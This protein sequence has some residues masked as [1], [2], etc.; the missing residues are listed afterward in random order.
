MS[1][2]GVALRRRVV[3]VRVAA[4][5]AWAG[6]VDEVVNLRCWLARGRAGSRY[7]VPRVGDRVR[8]DGK[9]AWLVWGVSIRAGE[10][11][12]G[13]GV[14]GLE[15]LDPIGPD[16]L[17]ALYAASTSTELVEP[18]DSNTVEET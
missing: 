18:I 9:G 14:H 4:W 5:R 12:L 8:V 17:A 3:A 11:T 2:Q 6:L 7:W 10:V 15:R 16:E 1:G 13:S